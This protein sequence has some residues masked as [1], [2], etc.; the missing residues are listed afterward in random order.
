LKQVGMIA[1]MA[2]LAA[3][4]YAL[5]HGV[6]SGLA[7][8]VLSLGFGALLSGYLYPRFVAVIQRCVRPDQI[9]YAMGVAVALYYIPG[10]FAGYFFALLIPLLGWPLASTLSV[11]LP[12]VIGLLCLCLC[13]TRRMRG[14]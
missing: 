13:D 3:I 8:A 2:G 5:F 12:P 9:G 14:S 7:H 4:G 10:L 11:A 1:A 6:T